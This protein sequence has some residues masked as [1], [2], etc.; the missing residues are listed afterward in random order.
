MH[1]TLTV[2]NG[3]E[4]AQFRQMERD[5]A[6]T[7]YFADPYCACQRGLNENT[8]GLLRQY[9]PKKTDLHGT[10]EEQVQKIVDELND[11]PRKK[12]QY[13]TPRER[14]SNMCGALDS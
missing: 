13:Q 7:I 9:F 6:L 1:H 10:T 5:T 4:F 14:F 3:K 2:D 8:N 11:R 12:I